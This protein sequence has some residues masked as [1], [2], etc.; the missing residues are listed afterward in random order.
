MRIIAGRFGKRSFPTPKG[1]KLRPTT[2]QAREALASALESRMELEGLLVLDLFSGT[3]AIGLE[4][5][6]R[7]V[8][9]VTFVDKQPKHI[10]FIKSVL[11]ALN[12]VPPEGRTLVK[13]VAKFLDSPIGQYDLVFADPPYNLPWL[14]ELPSRILEAGLLKHNGWMVIEHPTE[15]KF[16]QHPLFMH[17][18]SYSAVNFSFFFLS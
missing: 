15:I 12:I 6:S 10:A 1:L 2:E 18:R 17:Q 3:G 4:L 9:E 16:T 5:L 14:A 13:D 7:G 11:A 8:A